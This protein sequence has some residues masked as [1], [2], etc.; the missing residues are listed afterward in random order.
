MSSPK[1]EEGTWVKEKTGTTGMTVI[2]NID[3]EVRCKFDDE[4]GEPTENTFREEDLVPL[5]D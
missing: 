1:F 5:N 3:G 2:S 4:N